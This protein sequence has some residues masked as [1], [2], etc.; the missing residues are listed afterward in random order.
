MKKLIKRIR[1]IFYK[2]LTFYVSEFF[3]N[4][5]FF[6]VRYRVGY[7]SIFQYRVLEA[8]K[9]TAYDTYAKKSSK[10]FCSFQDAV[11]WVDGMTVEKFNQYKLEE[12]EKF[13][14]YS[15]HIKERIKVEEDKRL[16]E[17]VVK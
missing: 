12:E 4:S 9:P 2:D 17:R 10:L 15:K 3:P 6:R 1:S 5:I 8:D 16:Y 11:S 7:F 14:E 13:K